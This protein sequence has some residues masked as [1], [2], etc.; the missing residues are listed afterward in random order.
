MKVG[1]ELSD[2]E[3]RLVH[4]DT[5]NLPAVVQLQSI[6]L[7]HGNKYKDANWR[8]SLLMDGVSSNIQR[9]KIIRD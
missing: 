8:F 2:F 6:N 5:D 9:R 7:L 1:E 4:A 3:R